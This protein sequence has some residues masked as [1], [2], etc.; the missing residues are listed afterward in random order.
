MRTDSDSADHR[1]TIHPPAGHTRES[2]AMAC[3]TVDRLGEIIG[4]FP[5]NRAKPQCI[6]DLRDGKCYVY[7]IGGKNTPVKIGFSSAPYERLAALQT[8]HWER[9]GILAMVEGNLGDEAFY[10]AKFSSSR[11]NGEWF[12]RCAKI[13]AEIARLSSPAPFAAGG[14]A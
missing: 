5:P 2:W 3:D 13:D 8:A 12:T 4:D 1:R 9:L 7:F 10:H 6:Q 14:A 11:L